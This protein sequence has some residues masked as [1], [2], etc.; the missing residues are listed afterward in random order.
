MTGT[1]KKFNSISVQAMSKNM[2]NQSDNQGKMEVY[3]FVDYSFFLCV[4]L[5]IGLWLVSSFCLVCLCKFTCLF[6]S[7]S[8][9]PLVSVSLLF[10]LHV[11]IVYYFFTCSSVFYI[12]QF[13]STV[14]HCILVR[15]Q[16]S[17]L[18]FT[19]SKSIRAIRSPLYSRYLWPKQCKCSSQSSYFW[20]VIY[21]L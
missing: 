13:F 14:V 19:L 3:L 18:Q 20:F 16:R 8:F 1:R 15:A 17:S 21:L 5:H 4:P 7:I 2:A 6:L 12:S 11:S 10:H 9:R